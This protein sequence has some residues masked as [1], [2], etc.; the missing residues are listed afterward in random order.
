MGLFGKSR[1]KDETDSA[2]SDEDAPPAYAHEDSEYAAPSDSKAALLDEDDDDK[3]DVVVPGAVWLDAVKADKHGTSIVRREAPNDILYTFTLE[4]RWTN[5]TVHMFHGSV[6]QDPEQRPAHI[7]PFASLKSSSILLRDAPDQVE[8]T[9]Y[10]T[11]KLIRLNKWY[12]M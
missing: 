5:P 6:Q 10:K 7:L 1:A 4:K 9:K 2:S 11:K 3:D 8:A 12:G